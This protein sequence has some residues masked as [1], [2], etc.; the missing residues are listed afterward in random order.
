MTTPGANDRLTP[1]MEVNDSLVSSLKKSLEDYRR[2]LTTERD[3][4]NEEIRRVDRD[5]AELTGG[6]TSLSLRPLP[7][8]TGGTDTKR[9]IPGVNEAKIREL[10]DKDPS[11]VLTPTQIKQK[12]GIPRTSAR[13]V[14]E[15]MTD[16]VKGD[17]GKWHRRRPLDVSSKQE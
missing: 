8:E 14:L 9:P 4:L 15:R 12:T 7:T 13:S 3:E 16:M 1:M 11:L 2:R 17:G 5:I 6:S 10:F